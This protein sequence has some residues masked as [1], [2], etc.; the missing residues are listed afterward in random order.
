M[1]FSMPRILDCNMSDCSYND[2]EE[3]HAMAITVGGTSHDCD[4]FMKSEKKGGVKDIRGRVGAC[5]I[6]MC[7]YNESL[8]CSAMEIH[9]GQHTG[10]AECDTFQSR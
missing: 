5:K 2:G 1:A 7:R 10:H 8:E 6:E 9:M 3:C 4:T